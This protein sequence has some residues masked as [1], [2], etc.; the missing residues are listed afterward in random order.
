MN[1]VLDRG[2]LLKQGSPQDEDAIPTS[3]TILLIPV[4][5]GSLWD[6]PSAGIQSEQRLVASVSSFAYFVLE[7]TVGLVSLLSESSDF[8]T[9]VKP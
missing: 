1:R 8:K 7:A 6:T 4:P 5:K 2:S 3:N 9:L